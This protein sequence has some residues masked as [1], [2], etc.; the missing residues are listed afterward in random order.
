MR[1]RIKLC[2]S[3]KVSY[4][5][6]SNDSRILERAHHISG[7]YSAPKYAKL[8]QDWL[9]N[10]STT[11]G[12]IC[13]KFWNLDPIFARSIY[14]I[15]LQIDQSTFCAFFYTFCTFFSFRG[16]LERRHAVNSNALPLKFGEC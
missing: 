5:Q 2:V 15:L 13:L 1:A 6:D 10:I 14:V 3:I 4:R 12:P 8:R 7:R 9:D 11:T 16:F